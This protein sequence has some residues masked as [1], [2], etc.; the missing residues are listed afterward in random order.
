[1]TGDRPLRLAVLLTTVAGI[2]TLVAAQLLAPVAGAAGAVLLAAASLWAVRP[3]SARPRRWTS[4]GLLAGTFT[5]TV[6]STLAGGLDG[7]GPT[8]ALLLLGLTVAHALVLES[9]RDLTV[10]LA[11][12]GAMVLVAAGLAPGLALALPLGLAWVAGVAALVLAHDQRGR[13]GVAAVLGEARPARRVAVTVLTA[14]LVGLLAFL[15][16]PRP[17]S[18]SDLAARSRLAGYG[19][20]SPAGPEIGR[21]ARAWSSGVL[22][23][24]WRGDLG[25][26]AVL[27]VSGDEAQLWRAGVL[28][29]YDGTRWS[30]PTGRT[31]GLRG[32]GRARDIPAAAEDGP[33][34][35]QRLETG[36]VRPAGRPYDAV[37]APGRPVR[38]VTDGVVVASDTQVQLW[39]SGPYSVTSA[40]P[41]T[42]PERLRQATGADPSD[43]WT[44]LP[45]ALPARVSALGR[46]LV[47]AAP[48]RYDAVRAV[49]AHLRETATYRLDSPVP[50]A[51]EDAVDVFLFRDRTGFCEQFAA[52]A[53]VLLRA[54]G[55]P[56]RLVTGFSGGAPDGDR[57]LLR[58]SDAHAWVE[59]WFPGVGWV[60]SDPTAGAALADE[61]VSVFTGLR[62]R[63][64]RL[65]ESAGGRLLLATALV[66]P[67]ALVWLYR[68]RRP[69]PTAVAPPPVRGPLLAAYGRF[70]TALAVTGAPRR[71]AEGLD[72]LAAR[73][74]DAAGALGVVSRT[75]YARAA[76]ALP[77]S[78]AAI[79]TL[80]RLSASL[81]A[82]PRPSSSITRT[83]G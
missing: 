20:S 59:V 23:M 69:G 28:D 83:P 50:G 40:V 6:T 27:S 12:G 74:P 57:R 65:L 11:L 2:G 1:V 29:T 79:E 3:S 43:R 39:G 14:V 31:V 60:P 21:S 47:A 54:G 81:L 61:G 4:T 45:A 77:E 42:T 58:E 73:V 70:E 55:V 67:P 56:A 33:V 34:P 41:D 25:D 17:P 32:P 15:L 80:D 49:E 36:D 22:D 66:L 9:V 71:P 78:R 30:A 75:L 5:M 16:L 64:T 19:Q 7:A 8:L 52:A 76:P 26:A 35:G 53:V 44:A 51:G 82:S 24:R 63:L 62:N 68:R 46:E 10:G 13:T 37:V 72:A 18:L 38:V 48:S